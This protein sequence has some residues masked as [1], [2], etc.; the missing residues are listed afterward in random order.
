MVPSMI[1]DLISKLNLK[2]SFKSL[3]NLSI[4]NSRQTL[5]NLCSLFHPRIAKIIQNDLQLMCYLFL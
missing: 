4:E 1:L 2:V 3:H 5:S